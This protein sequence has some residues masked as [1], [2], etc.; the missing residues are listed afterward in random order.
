MGG[1]N[2]CGFLQTTV[3]MVGRHMTFIVSLDDPV[4]LSISEENWHA[5][6]S[7]SNDLVL[8]GLHLSPAFVRQPSRERGIQLAIHPL[9]SRRL[10]GVPSAELTELGIEGTDV[11]GRT[12]VELRERI[13]E[14][15]SWAQRFDLLNQ[16]LIDAG[17]ESA[18]REQ[19]RPELEQAW[20]LLESSRGRI[21]VH[22]LAAAVFLSSRQLSKLFRQELGIGPKSLARLMR[23]DHAIARISASAR[24]GHMPSFANTAI[25][26]GY[27][28]QSHFVSDFRQFTGTTPSQWLG[29]EFRNIQAGGHGSSEYS[30]V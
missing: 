19:V 1:I 16:Y 4:A 12:A 14:M 24:A 7:T 17:A 28:D 13:H 8:A 25:D 29:E 18:R 11:L 30:S 26:C 10:F 23:F 9:A 15:P 5:D 22:E 20:H 27:F 21:P 6:R 3:S 2:D